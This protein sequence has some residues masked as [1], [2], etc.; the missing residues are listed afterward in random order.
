MRILIV[1]DNESIAEGIKC[2]LKKNG[3]NV[4][5]KNNI[6]K[7]E[8]TLKINLFDF[9]IL[10]ILLPDGSGL[11]LC[12]KIKD[13]LDIPVIFLTAKDMEV[14][15][16]HGLEIGADDYI[17]KPFRMGELMA[18]INSV[19]RRYKNT[20]VIERIEKIKFDIDSKQIY[21]EDKKID[22]TKL[23]WKILIILLNAKGKIVSREKLINL[24]YNESG[25]YINDNTLSVYIKRMRKKL[26]DNLENPRIIKT[27]RG[28]GYKIEGADNK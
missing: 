1:E 10:D 19:L 17:V 21:N 2:Y 15:I 20:S 6:V 23:E 22:F 26:G 14:D 18:R 5:I 28:V 25:N 11:E 27:I 24:I 12:K 9:V 8:E 3:H 16:I 4:I 7:T 13:T